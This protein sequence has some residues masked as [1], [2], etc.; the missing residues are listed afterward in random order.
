MNWPV[1]LADEVVANL[2]PADYR[3]TEVS[4]TMTG[5]VIWVFVPEDPD[6]GLLWVRLEEYRVFFVIS[7][8]PQENQ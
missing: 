3:H 6:H 2:T 1:E 5:A 4:R 7:F 8:H